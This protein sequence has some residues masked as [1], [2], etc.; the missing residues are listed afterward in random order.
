M[1]G[2]SHHGIH[3]TFLNSICKDKVW[4]LDWDLN[5]NKLMHVD[6]EIQRPH[7]R[8]VYRSDQSF[9]VIRSESI[10]S[11]LNKKE[12]AEKQHFSIFE[13]DD[14]RLMLEARDALLK[15]SNDVVGIVAGYISNNTSAFYTRNVDALSQLISLDITSSKALATFFALKKQGKTLDVCAREALKKEANPNVAELL[16]KILKAH[17]EIKRDPLVQLGTTLHFSK[18]L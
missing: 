8:F 5:N 11:C 12:E 15:L 16:N 14:P 9:V 4:K 18:G 7:E 6:V 10:S 1:T 3:L 13:Y 17:L 2:Q